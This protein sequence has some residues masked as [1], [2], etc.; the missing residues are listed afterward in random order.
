VEKCKGLPHR[1]TIRVMPDEKGAVSLR[2]RIQRKCLPP[3][4]T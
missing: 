1:V 4:Q 2:D 3:L